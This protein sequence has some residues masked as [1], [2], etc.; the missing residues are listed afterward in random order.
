MATQWQ[1]DFWTLRLTNK[2]AL[3]AAYDAA[4]TALA[5]GVMSYTI[6]TGQTTQTV[7]RSSVGQIL[8]IIKQLEREIQELQELL[9]GVDGRAVYVRPGF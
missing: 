8:G 2:I 9:A 4:S 5:T 3:L 1:I 6:N 7:T